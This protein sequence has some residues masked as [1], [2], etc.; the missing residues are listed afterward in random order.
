MSTTKQRHVGAALCTLLCAVA[1]LAESISPALADTFNVI[2]GESPSTYQGP[3]TGSGATGSLSSGQRVAIACSIRGETV[4][5]PYGATDVWDYTHI[6]NGYVSDAFIY[7][8]RADPVGPQCGGAENHYEYATLGYLYVNQPGLDRLYNEI[9]ANPTWNP[10]NQNRNWGIFAAK[11]GLHGE[12]RALDY[13]MSIYNSTEYNAGWNLANYLKANAK[14]YGIQ[15]II[16]NDRAWDMRNPTAGWSDYDEIANCGNTSDTC[17]HNDHLHIGMNWAGAVL[18]TRRWEVIID[19][20][21]RN[22]PAGTS[23]SYSTNWNMST[24]VPGYYATGFRVA[25]VQP[26]VEDGVTFSFYLSP[27]EPKAKTIAAWW[28]T[29]PARNTA[30]PFVV[31]NGNGQHL[32]TAYANQQQNGARW[33]T[34]GTWTFSAGWN[35]VT[36]SRWA[37][38]N[39]GEK[40]IA[41][42]I[43]IRG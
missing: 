7:T 31:R 24:Y 40:V 21:A 42:A 22:N 17:K 20:A 14:T 6:E 27:S 4:S 43:R 29:G 15:E 34:L 41:D 38:P 23:V 30:T 5:G 10:G 33:N 3:N 2:A 28:T 26:G 11:P 1:V 8:G 36:V 12:G 16:W 37:D 32:G 13:R 18:K 9:S 25:K 35:T 19:D 39:N